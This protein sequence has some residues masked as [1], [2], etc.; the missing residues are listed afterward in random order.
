MQMNHEE[1][2]TRLEHRLDRIEDKLD[3]HLRATSGHESDLKWLQGYVRLSMVLF[4][5]LAGAVATALFPII[6]E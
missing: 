2:Y 3:Q 4:I 6:L 5:T 1:L